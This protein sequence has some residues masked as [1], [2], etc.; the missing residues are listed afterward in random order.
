M[1]VETNGNATVTKQR[2]QEISTEF[3]NVGMAARQAG[4]LGQTAF[5]QIFSKLGSL[6]TYTSAIFMIMKGIKY[7]II[8]YKVWY[9]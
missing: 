9:S 6:T 2:I 5:Q 1:L 3:N 7:I 4:K 8:S